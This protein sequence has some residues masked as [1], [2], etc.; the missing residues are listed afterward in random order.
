[1]NNTR[2]Y[3]FTIKKK[4]LKSRFYFLRWKKGLSK[5]SA[6]VCLSN[7]LSIPLTSPSLFA[8]SESKGG[9]CMYED[10]GKSIRLGM[11]GTEWECHL[12]DSVRKRLC[13]DEKSLDSRPLQWR[14][15]LLWR[16]RA[17]VFRLFSLLRKAWNSYRT[18][19]NGQLKQ[20]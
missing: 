4:I 15:W 14:I 11:G 18:K 19:Y 12:N 6:S 5:L 3:L 17:E 13:H 9:I 2:Q 1:M 20:Q 7:C 8:D 16:P 10:F